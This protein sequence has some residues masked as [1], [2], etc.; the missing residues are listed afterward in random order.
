MD[1]FIILKRRYIA[2]KFSL[3]DWRIIQPIPFNVFETLISDY[4]ENGW[5]IESDYPQLT[6]D[7]R[8]WQCKLRRG[9]TVL[10][11]KWRKNEQ[12]EVVG[13]ARVVDNIGAVLNIPVYSQP[14]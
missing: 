7:S 10:A 6:P 11:C 12:G 5:E 4:V 1:L 8:K 2:R 3:K 9:S 14:Q 13:A